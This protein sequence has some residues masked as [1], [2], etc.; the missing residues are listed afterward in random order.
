MN[1]SNRYYNSFYLK[2]F[3]EIIWEVEACESMAQRLEE[4]QC[5]EAAFETRKIF[6]ELRDLAA[7]IEER[8]N[9]LRPLWKVIEKYDE[10]EIGEE[11]VISALAKYNQEFVKTR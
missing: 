1:L 6:E 5:R 3:P 11:Q 2:E 7:S 8:L 9:T 4:L 10:G